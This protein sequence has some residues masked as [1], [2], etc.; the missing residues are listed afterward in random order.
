MTTP[1]ISSACCRGE[2]PNG[3]NSRLWTRSRSSKWKVPRSG[4]GIPGGWSPATL[5][6]GVRNWGAI[7]PEPPLGPRAQPLD[8][9]RVRGDDEPTGNEDVPGYDHR[10]CAHDAGD[11][12]GEHRYGC[13]AH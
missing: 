2:L 4:S 7:P 6:G 3:S 9:V 10:Y 1:C 8:V 13:P 12:R 5:P 11:D